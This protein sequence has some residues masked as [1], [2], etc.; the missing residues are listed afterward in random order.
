[1]DLAE[2]TD[3]LFMKIGQKLKNIRLVRFRPLMLYNKKAN[4]A[5]GKK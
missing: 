2:Y 3:E 5:R 1:V 4:F